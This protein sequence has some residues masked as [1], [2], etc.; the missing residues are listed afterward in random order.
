MLLLDDRERVLLFQDSDAAV[1]RRWW[2]LPGGGIDAGED[3]L[4]AVLREI[5]EETGCRLDASDVRGPIARRHVTHG[6][7]DVV[8]EQ[9]DAFYVV[10]VPAFEVSTAG[11]TADE[12]QTL[13]GH[14]WWTR[15][16]LDTATDAI[17]PALL[18][19]LWDLAATPAHWPRQLEDIE[20]SSVPV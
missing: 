1:D 4:A 10:A 16:E 12:Q 19:E 7:S 18:P 14:R 8:V 6:Y 2:I 13:L 11:H 3:E 15:A 20:E 9:D 17:W 5:E